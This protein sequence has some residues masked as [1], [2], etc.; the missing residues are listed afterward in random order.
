MAAARRGPLPPVLL[1]GALVGQWAVH[2]LLPVAVVVPGA[3]R[4]VGSVLIVMGVVVMVWA[5]RQFKVANTAINP[6]DTPS[7]MVISGPFRVSRN[8]MYVAMLLI[9]TGGA[10]A[11]GTL[12]PFLFVPL[13][14]WPLQSKFVRMEEASMTAAF[15]SDYEDYKRRVRRWL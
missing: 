1:L 7:S 8:P 5:D 9:L 6:F 13:L 11:W 4:T 14:A 10:V 2:A 12:T 3:W 15:G